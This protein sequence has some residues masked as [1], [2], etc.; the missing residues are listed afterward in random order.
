MA[1]VRGRRAAGVRDGGRP[2]SAR[3]SPCAS[4]QL[5]L[6]APRRQPALWSADG[7]RQ[8]G[9][10]ACVIDTGRGRDTRRQVALL[11]GSGHFS[12][13]SLILLLAV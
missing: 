9:L 10:W 12:S 11:R 4:P 13:S 8:R 3:G 2:G 7:S 6:L 5:L 1:G